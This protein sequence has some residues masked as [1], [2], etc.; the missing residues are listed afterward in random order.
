MQL[1]QH[2]GNHHTKQTAKTRF[3]C[4]VPG[5]GIV[6]PKT[7][8]L[9]LYSLFA[10]CLLATVSFSSCKKDKHSDE[11][12]LY[13]TWVNRNAPGDTLVFMKKNNRNILSMSNTF[14]PTMT[15]RNEVEYTFA[16]QKLVVNT[17]IVSSAPRQEISSFN[18]IEKNKTF[19]INGFQLYLFMSSTLTKFV[20]VKIKD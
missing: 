18:W 17:S 11:Q 3:E 7:S 2:F 20:Y 13:G 10:F 4:N 19:E 9:K 6:S 1:Y 8:A 14:N 5:A 12:E 16:D 15:V